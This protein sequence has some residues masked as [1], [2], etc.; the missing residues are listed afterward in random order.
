ME[1]TIMSLGDAKG[2]IGNGNK[3]FENTYYSRVGFKDYDQK[4]RLGFQ[5]KSGMLVVDL[6]KE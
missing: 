3:V 6:S 4:L 1:V 2:K 5:Y